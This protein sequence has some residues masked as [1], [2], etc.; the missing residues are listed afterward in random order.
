M[1]TTPVTTNS[2]VLV[3]SHVNKAHLNVKRRVVTDCKEGV[4][5]GQILH[6]GVD[7]ERGSV[8]ALFGTDQVGWG[9]ATP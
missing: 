8:T 6:T 1:N 2:A 4:K 7:T 5:K 3:M 9:A